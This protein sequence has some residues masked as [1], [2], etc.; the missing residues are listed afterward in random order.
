MSTLGSYKY[1]LY[2]AVFPF[3]SKLFYVLNLDIVTK[4]SENIT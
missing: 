3:F 1:T 4:K 2:S